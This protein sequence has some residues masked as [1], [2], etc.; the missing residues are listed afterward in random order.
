M[1]CTITC[2]DNRSDEMAFVNITCVKGHLN[3][4]LNG[5]GSIVTTSLSQ[6]QLKKM[7]QLDRPIANLVNDMPE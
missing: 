6:Q 7:P 5:E 1:G 3:L 2:I 4:R